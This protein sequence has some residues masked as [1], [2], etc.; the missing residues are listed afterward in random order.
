RQQLLLG[1]CMRELED[2]PILPTGLLNHY[3]SAP[4]GSPV[5]GPTETVE[6]VSDPIS[7]QDLFNIW[8]PLKPN[9][10]LSAAYVARMIAID[11]LVEMEDRRAVQA[12]AFGFGE[13]VAP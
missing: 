8:D 3:G 10:H 4:I 13:M 6:L 2:V 9:V 1:W 7:L 12:H 11:S 5:F